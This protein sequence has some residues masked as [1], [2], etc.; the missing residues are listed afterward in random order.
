MIPSPCYLRQRGLDPKIMRQNLRIVDARTPRF[1]L[2]PLRGLLRNMHQQS[3]GEIC[4]LIAVVQRETTQHSRVAA[5]TIEATPLFAGLSQSPA[6][7]VE[8]TFGTS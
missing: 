5:W 6:G 7:I 4:Y 2:G 8:F 1:P 3:G